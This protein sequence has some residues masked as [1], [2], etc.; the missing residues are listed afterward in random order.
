LIDALFEHPGE[1]DK[2]ANYVAEKIAHA[3]ERVDYVAFL[4]TNYRIWVNLKGAID[5][6][7][8]TT[9]I[10]PYNFVLR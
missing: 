2:L 10:A 3:K 6:G 4:F 7:V 1:V 8:S 9:V 5:R